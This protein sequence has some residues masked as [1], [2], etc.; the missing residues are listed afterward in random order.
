MVLSDRLFFSV[1]SD[2]VLLTVLSNRVFFRVLNNKVFF[3]VL[4]DRILNDR[5]F[6]RV[7]L[8]S[9]LESSVI[10]SSIIF[11]WCGNG[12]HVFAKAP[13]SKRQHD[14][15]KR[16]QKY[17]FNKQVVVGYNLKFIDITTGFSWE[18]P[19]FKDAWTCCTIP[20]S[21]QQWS[22][23]RVKSQYK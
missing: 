21:K 16:K 9:S 18:H 4:G 19:W 22:I 13:I 20:E 17:P 7:P 5:V 14:Y 10:G 12:T 8:G 3:S 1:L 2:R 11:F 6:F 15:Y 23:V